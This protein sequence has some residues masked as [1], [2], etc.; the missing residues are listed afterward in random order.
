M[1]CEPIVFD[2][3]QHHLDLN[4]VKCFSLVLGCRNCHAGVHGDCQ[5]RFTFNE[6]ICNHIQKNGLSIGTL[7][8][9]GLIFGRA[10]QDKLDTREILNEILSSRYQFRLNTPKENYDSLNSFERSFYRVLEKKIHRN[11][12]NGFISDDLRVRS[13]YCDPTPIPNGKIC[14]LVRWEIDF[15]LNENDIRTAARLM[16]HENVLISRHS[17]IRLQE[18]LRNAQNV[19]RLSDHIMFR[20]FEVI[21]CL[22]C[23][24]LNPF[25][26]M[27]RTAINL[28]LQSEYSNT[29][30]R[31]MSCPDTIDCAV[32]RLFDTFFYSDQPKLLQALSMIFRLHKFPSKFTQ[33]MESYCLKIIIESDIKECLSCLN[34]AM[35][36]EYY[37]GVSFHDEILYWFNL[38][39]NSFIVDD[40]SLLRQVSIDCLQQAIEDAD[41]LN[42]INDCVIAIKGNLSILIDFVKGQIKE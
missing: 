14:E 7:M 13:D 5:A 19:H 34:Q 32:E 27:H 36:N 35:N 28:S 40:V 26:L 22:S 24:E 20:Y 6:K 39:D 16:M 3:V 2:H 9:A 33:L 29:V 18:S 23:F 11:V 1:H 25:G 17:R 38:E 10:S 41:H 4:E 8:N 31:P 21:P 15:A 12:S 42:L 30:L 37:C